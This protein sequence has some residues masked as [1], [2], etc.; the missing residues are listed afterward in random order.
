MANVVKGFLDFFRL[1]DEDEDFYD[2]FDDY[3]SKEQER[4]L[5]RAARA[6][7]KAA[8]KQEERDDSV[9]GLSNNTSS[10]ARRSRNTKNDS[11]KIV[12][13]RSTP[14]GFEVSIMKPTVFEDSQDVCDLLMSGKV[15][16]INLEGFDLDIAQRIMDFVSGCVYA[17]NGKLHQ[18]SN[19]I[20]IV[21]PE[22]ID[23]SG[24]YLQL[25]ESNGF[26]VPTLNKEF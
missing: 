11:S 5:K 24:D 12:P 1:N 23:I 2:D 13:I 19:Y 18:I 16:V 14:K 17:I 26:E 9:E 4:A 10:F 7:K 25:L 8:A 15:T 22:N 3:D 20:F 6:E 21:T